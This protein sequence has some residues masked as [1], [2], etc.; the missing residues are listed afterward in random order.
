MDSN[1]VL[2]MNLNSSLCHCDILP[3]LQMASPI[4]KLT[5]LRSYFDGEKIDAYLLPSTDA[6]QVRP[7]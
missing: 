2:G 7:H 4:E 6:H 3:L 5:N 1:D